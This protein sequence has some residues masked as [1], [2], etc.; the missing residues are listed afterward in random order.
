MGKKDPC[1]NIQ[2]CT[3]LQRVS[4]MLPGAWKNNLLPGDCIAGEEKYSADL[5]KVCLPV[6]FTAQTM[7]F[8]QLCPSTLLHN[9]SDARFGLS[10]AKLSAHWQS[11]VFTNFT[12]WFMRRS[13]EINFFLQLSVFIPYTTDPFTFH[14]NRWVQHYQC[15][16][17]PHRP[18]LDLWYPFSPKANQS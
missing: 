2:K 4:L 16:T 6:L 9:R 18:A 12:L 13:Q 14:L 17:I 1:T 5:L 15:T 10:A 11:T 8:S 7:I 3:K